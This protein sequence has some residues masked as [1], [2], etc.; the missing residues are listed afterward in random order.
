MNEICV[1]KSSPRN[2]LAENTKKVKQIGVSM[3]DLDGD[4]DEVLKKMTGHVDDLKRLRDTISSCKVAELDA[5]CVTFDTITSGYNAQDAIAKGM[6]AALEYIL[7]ESRDEIRHGQMAKRYQIIKIRNSLVAG[8]FSRPLAK[9][10][11]SRLHAA[12]NL[13]SDVWNQETFDHTRVLFYDD[14][15]KV[16]GRLVDKMTKII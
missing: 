16:D 2:K 11:G 14:K 3:A 6:N 15:M 8:G 5:K 4:P 9:F 12:Q 13:S 1:P 7:S 10:V